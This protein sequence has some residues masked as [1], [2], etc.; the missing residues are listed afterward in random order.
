MAKAFSLLAVVPFSHGHR[1][2]GTHRG[3]CAR[4]EVLNLDTDLTDILNHQITHDVQR[5][6]GNCS[7]YPHPAGAGHVGGL[8][9]RS[10]DRQAVIALVG[11]NQV[12]PGIR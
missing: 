9:S 7:P 8:E 3:A 1:V 10:Q 12:G 11:R 2:H 6:L 5:G 4:V